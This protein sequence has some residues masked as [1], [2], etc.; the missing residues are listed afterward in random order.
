M[1]SP[2]CV[3]AARSPEPTQP[4]RRVQS[5]IGSPIDVIDWNGALD[6]IAGWSSARQ[7]RVVCLCNVHSV[8]TASKDAAFAAAI[9][10][11]DLALPD[12]APV[13][14]LMRRL[15]HRRQRRLSGPDLMWRSC[16]QAARSGDAVY[17]FGSTATTLALLQLRLQQSFPALRIV[18]ACSPPFRPATPAED[19]LIVEDIVSSGASIVWVG[20]GCP[21]QEQWMRAHRGRIPAVMLGVG[22]AFD[23][24]AGTLRRAPAW[25]QRSG[26]EWLHRLASEPGR[27][28]RR[29]LGSNSAF[30]VAALVQWV[31]SIV[32]RQPPGGSAE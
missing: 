24:H 21:K 17:L 28:W 11:A 23:Y 22:A 14:W 1:E 26:L 7:S 2:A 25:M 8:V 18:G 16:E 31:G 4:D 5:V 20:L 30:V 9:G 12:G 3:A 10:D 32:R 15:G 13:A 6:R 19:D 27:L 29:Y